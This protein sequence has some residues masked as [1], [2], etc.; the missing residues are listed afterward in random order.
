MKLAA[1]LL[2][3]IAATHYGYAPLAEQFSDPD[4]AARA[5]F[6]VVRGIE[7]V[8]LFAAIAWLSPQP[9]VLLACLWGVL[10]EGETAVCRMSM[11]IGNT[12]QAGLFDGLCGPG[13]YVLGVCIAA[14]LAVFVTQGARRNE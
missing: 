11:G 12:V 2:L 13:W 4:G 8:A 7:G 5:I 3:V 1:L 10:E 6:Y 9:A 14:G